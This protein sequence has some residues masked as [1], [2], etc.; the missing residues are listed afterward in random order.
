MCRISNAIP[1]LCFGPDFPVQQDVR[2]KLDILHHSD[3]LGVQP[4]MAIVAQY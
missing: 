1:Y 2:E 4:K 3:R